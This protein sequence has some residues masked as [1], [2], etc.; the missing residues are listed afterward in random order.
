MYQD[1]YNLTALPFQLTPDH[2]F[3][4][5]STVHNRALAHLTYGLNQGEGFI[6]ITGEVGAGKTTMVGHLLATLDSTKFTAGKVVTTQLEAD[7]MLRMVASAFGLETDGV[8]KASLLRNIE[9]LLRSIHGEGRRALLLVDEAQNLTIGA[10]E[11]LRMLSNFQVEEKTA[12][13]CFL[14]GQP[15]FRRTL[16]TPD[17]DQLR[18]RVIAAYHL[19]PL[20][21]RE[22]REYIEHRL[23]TAGWKNDPRFTDSAFARVYAVTGGVPR[24]INTLCSRLLLYGFLEESHEI[25]G[26]VVDRVAEE[27]ETETRQIIDPGPGQRPP[28]AAEITRPKPGTEPAPLAPNADLP[29]GG[30]TEARLNGSHV[31]EELVR[32]L[33]VLEG[34]VRLHERI[35]KKALGIATQYLEGRQEHE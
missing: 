24:M 10:L 32:R 2:R 35:I 11:E 13:Q 26:E 6:I 19:E 4:F 30:E 7:D 18:Q 9:A 12:L 31:D 25:D 29:A 17:L 21:E 34:Y 16:A 8:S 1:F 3:F 22:T 28:G 23:S 15:Q 33:E 14:L 20:S 27:H 5:G